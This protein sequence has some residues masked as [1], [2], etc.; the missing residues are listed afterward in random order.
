MNIFIENSCDPI[1]KEDNPHG[2]HR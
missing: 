2:S 1:K